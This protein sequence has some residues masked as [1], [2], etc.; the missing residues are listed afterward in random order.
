M[1]NNE[2]GATRN[3]YPSALERTIEV[4]SKGRWVK[5]PAIECAGNV[6]VV[7]GKLIKI[8]AVH[9]EI[10]LEN[11]INDPELC[12]QRLR[13]ARSRASSADIFTFAQKPPSI[14]TQY[15]YPRDLESLAAIPLTTFDD[16]WKSVPQETRKNVRRAQKRG[17]LVRTEQFSDELVR[18]ILDVN[19]DS[20]VRQGR[21]YTH[22][23]KSFEQVRKDHE[24]F[25]DRSIFIC[26]YFEEEMIGFMK[27]VYRGEVASIL[28]LTPKAS[29]SDKR[30][31]NAMLAKAVEVCT[32]NHKSYL[33]YGM[34]NQGNKGDTPIR[35]FKVRNG[36]KEIKMPRYY[37]PL[38][39][40]G[41]VCVRMKLYRG[42]IGLLPAWIILFLAK[43]R[44]KVYAVRQRMSRC[45]SMTERPNCD[46]QTERSTPPAGSNSS[47]ITPTSS[48]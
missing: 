8:A 26:A 40:W 36:F 44:A 4:S 46:R 41:T 43:V 47:P 6:V 48:L 27:V 9:D 38:T 16:W 29:H 37:V 15:R 35:E 28:Q 3:P 14:E 21:R 1:T 2:S 33:V 32:A 11:S 31:A 7:T 22:F 25:T 34:F 5:V 23:G 10:W 13:D 18:G 19:N 42:L 30:P 39:T 24:A 17:V 12:I 45:S 20:P